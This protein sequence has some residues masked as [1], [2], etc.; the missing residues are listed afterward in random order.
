[1]S[2]NN[3]GRLDPE[4]TLAIIKMF[5]DVETQMD[6]ELIVKFEG[7]SI[8]GENL[9]TWGE[10]TLHALGY[11]FNVQTNRENSLDAGLFWVLR[12]IDVATASLT[13]AL[14]ACSG[15]SKKRMSV[16]LRVFKAGGS[17]LVGIAARPSIEFILDESY[18]KVQ[19]F[20]TSSPTGLPTEILGFEYKSITVETSPQLG[21][22]II[23][24]TRSCQLTW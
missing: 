2:W 15:A 17:D 3:D 7:S 11:F 1:M 13:S 20:L 8:Q 9:R 16:R 5:P 22:G 18:I 14:K 12:N 10:N 24:A 4:E 23:G 21:S 19:S 6:I